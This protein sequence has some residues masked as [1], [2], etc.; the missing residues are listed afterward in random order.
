MSFR[1][2]CPM[3][4]PP[5]PCHGMP[6]ESIRYNIANVYV[7]SRAGRKP[8]ATGGAMGVRRM[9]KKVLGFVEIVVG[10]ALTAMA[11]GLIVLR[12]GF[13]AGGVTGLG[14]ILHQWVPLPLSAI[15]F[16]LNICLFVL[17]WVFVSREFVLKTLVNTLLF[18]LML[19]FF[20]GIDLLAPLQGDP[21]LGA[22]LAGALLGLGS[23]LI[24]R[25]DGSSGGF[26]ILGVIAHKRNA[27]IPVSVVMN[28][29]DAL[30]IL[31]QCL[32]TPIMN[33]IYGL[34]VIAVTTALI[35]R[36]LS[37][38]A[39]Q[40]KVTIFS[41]DYAPIKEKLLTEADVGLTLLHGE[42]GYLGRE[43]EVIVTVIPYSKINAVKKCV[44]SVDPKAFV[45]VESAQA[46]LGRGYTIDREA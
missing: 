44:Y 45:V 9:S 37:F 15:V 30:M 18:P 3:V 24:L 17:G 16:I 41:E 42:S 7:T 22:V 26:D 21:F 35:N 46:V 13:V 40:S 43:T 8:P 11:F 29:C 39:G 19:E 23:G 38:G 12:L 28:T 20:Q 10:S 1:P 32:R 33:T 4:H 36:V 27:D 25:G 2:I 5:Q 14:V 6:E 31:A 34:V